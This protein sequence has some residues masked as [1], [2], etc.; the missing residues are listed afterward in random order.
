MI[1]NRLYLVEWEDTVR[2]FATWCNGD[3]ASYTTAK[4]WSAGEIPRQ[5]DEVTVVAASGNDSGHRANMDIIPTRA[6]VNVTEYIPKDEALWWIDALGRL[7]AV[8][9]ALQDE[10][11][12]SGSIESQDTL[13]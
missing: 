11:E 13:S 8:S 4:A 7:W 5:D 6:V 1:P 10:E 12:S 3:L 2:D 9:L